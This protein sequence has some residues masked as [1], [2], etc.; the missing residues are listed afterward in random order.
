MVQGGMGTAEALRASTLS[1]A[2]LCRVDADLGS[3]TVGKLADLIA[4]P[5]NPLEDI[6]ALRGIDVVIKAGSFV[7]SGDR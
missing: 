1:A 6:R 7:R 4:M 3:V 2:E 5:G